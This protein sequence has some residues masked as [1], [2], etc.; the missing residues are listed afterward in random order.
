MNARTDASLIALFSLPT[1]VGPAAVEDST[2]GGDGTGLED[3]TGATRMLTAV[4]LISA[5]WR[6]L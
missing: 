1:P 6:S 5:F 3:V 4:A 2:G